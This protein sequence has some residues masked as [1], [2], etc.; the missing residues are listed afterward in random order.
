M[1]RSGASTLTGTP[2]ACQVASG[3][4]G[5]KVW[6]FWL[7]VINSLITSIHRIRLMC[8]T[9]IP[10]YAIYK[11]WSSFLGPMI[12]GRS[13][14]AAPTEEGEG[15]ETLSKRQEKLKKRSERGDARVRV[16]RK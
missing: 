9:K 10:A 14:A 1:F 15:K 16:S 2:G 5:E 13:S 11:L 3:A 7:V 8:C 4:F 12:F 6:Y